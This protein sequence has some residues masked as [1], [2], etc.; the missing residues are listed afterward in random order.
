MPAAKLRPVGAQHR[1][2][3]RRS[4]TRSR[5]RRTPSTTAVAPELRTAKRSPAR[6]A[7][8]RLAGGRAV[9]HRVADEHAA[10]AGI[11]G[12][13]ERPHHQRAAAQ[14]LARR[15]RCTA[16]SRSIAQ[17]RAARNAPRLW[18]AYAASARSGRS[19]R[20][21]SPAAPCRRA[22]SP[23][24]NAPTLRSV[25]ATGGDDR[26]PP[27]RPAERGAAAG[28]QLA[29]PATARPSRAPTRRRVP[30]PGCDQRREV[31]AALGARPRCSRSARPTIS[32]RLRAPSSASSS[33]TP[34][35]QE[36]EVA[37][38]VLGRAGE[39]PPQLRILGGDPH[40]AGVQV[41]DA[42]HHAAGGHQRR[43]REGELLG[44]QERRDQHVAGGA[45]AAVHLQPHAVAQAVGGQHLLRL[46]QP[47]LPRQAG[48][49][50]RRQRRRR[51]CRRRGRRSRCGRPRPWP[52][53][54]RSCRRPP[55][56]PA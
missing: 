9:Q 38:D 36:Q 14:A 53:R 48:V 24:R 32:S 41:A 2:P 55:R 22:I 28:M 27:R 15:S 23:A 42:H 20:A 3:R 47:Q 12:A 8:E 49:L 16:P 44:A 29:C 25:F 19:R 39:P 21:G 40:R 31:E 51:R 35:G 5:G 13:L 56:R 18:P 34:L 54:R 37:D 45:Q 43:G 4:C 7:Q 11:A 30:A 1:A 33:R 6:A 10:L 17:A 50:E 46:G 52:R 26:A